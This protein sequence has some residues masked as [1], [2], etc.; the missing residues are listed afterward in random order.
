MVPI[1]IVFESTGGLLET[2]WEKLTSRVV[3]FTKF[4]T[5][6]ELKILRLSPQT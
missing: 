3:I 5:F 1:E 2:Q 4:G 6:V